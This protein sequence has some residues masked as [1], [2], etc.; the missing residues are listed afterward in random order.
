MAW[1]TYIWSWIDTIPTG[2]IPATVLA[3]VVR[4]YWGVAHWDDERLK[5]YIEDAAKTL[6]SQ[7]RLSWRPPPSLCRRTSRT[8]PDRSCGPVAPVA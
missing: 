2:L 4:Q 5:N 3:M 7:D 1:P 6:D 8:A